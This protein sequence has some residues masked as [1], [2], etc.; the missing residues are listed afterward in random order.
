MSKLISELKQEHN[1]IAN[2]F[3]TIVKLGATSNK[4]LDIVKKSKIKLLEHLEKED[5][6]LYPPLYEKAQKDVLLRN[7][8]KNFGEELE[9]VTQ[10]VLNFYSKYSNLRSINKQEFIEDMSALNISLKGRIMKE[11]YSLYRAY[12]KLNID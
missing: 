4:G 5:K 12:E 1:E 3:N 2:L 9:V 7:T 6:Y 8:L 11:E 10:S